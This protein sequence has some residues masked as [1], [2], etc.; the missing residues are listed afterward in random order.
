MN[1]TTTIAELLPY[2]EGRQL[3][4][5]N[6]TP[7]DLQVVVNDYVAAYITTD[8]IQQLDTAKPSEWLNCIAWGIFY[9]RFDLIFYEISQRGA[10]QLTGYNANP[11]Q[12]V[13]REAI[14]A[15]I[16]RIFT[17]HLRNLINYVLNTY[18]INALTTAGQNYNANYVNI[19]ERP[20]T[21]THI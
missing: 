17:S 6:F 7:G 20:L 11:A 16:E 13:E 15:Q 8:T 3:S 10:F 21:Y 12:S 2:L 18:G 1:L 5:N 19:I 4:E 9:I 14:K